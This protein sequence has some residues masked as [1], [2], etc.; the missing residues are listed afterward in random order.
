MEE[1][2]KKTVILSQESIVDI[3][4]IRRYGEETFGE[5]K[6]DEY[7]SFLMKSIHF[8]DVWYLMHPECRQLETKG[9]MYRHII[10][11]SH[12]I[13]YRIAK[14]VEVLRVLH[15]ASSNAKIRTVRKVKV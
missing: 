2:E 1:C 9:R 11:D 8:L 15:S 4:R 5:R 13:V 6:A 7:Y 12:I 14:C 3:D 10:T